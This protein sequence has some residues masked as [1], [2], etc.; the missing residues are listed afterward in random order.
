[1][2]IKFINCFSCVTTTINFQRLKI[3]LASL[4]SFHVEYIFL[5]QSVK[6]LMAKHTDLIYKLT[7]LVGVVFKQIDQI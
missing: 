5:K 7:L 4:L 3:L 6:L 2:E 1:M